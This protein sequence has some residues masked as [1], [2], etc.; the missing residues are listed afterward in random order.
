MVPAI[1]NIYSALTRHVISSMPQHSQVNSNAMAQKTFC[2]EEQKLYKQYLYPHM[3]SFP[4]FSGQVC[5]N[6]EKRRRMG[7]SVIISKALNLSGC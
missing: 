5:R 7:G 6:S 4:H 2:L 3:L 1:D